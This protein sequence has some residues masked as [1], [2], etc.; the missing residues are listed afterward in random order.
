MFI[1]REQGCQNAA[2]LLFVPAL[3]LF[4]VCVLFFFVAALQEALISYLISLLEVSG[5]RGVEGYFY[6]LRLLGLVHSGLWDLG[7]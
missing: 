4:V 2:L 6:V 5:F 7:P 3:S 1:L